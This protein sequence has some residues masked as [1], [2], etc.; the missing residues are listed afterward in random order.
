MNEEHITFQVDGK[1]FTTKLVSDIKPQNK[2]HYYTINESKDIINLILAEDNITEVIEDDD[3]SHP[4]IIES[5]ENSISSDSK[6]EM[7]PGNLKGKFL[8]KVIAFYK[9][10]C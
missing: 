9:N 2:V 5:E 1:K 6:V 3:E 7:I 8:D 10:K 4:I